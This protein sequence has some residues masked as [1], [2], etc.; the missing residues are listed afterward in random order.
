MILFFQPDTEQDDQALAKQQ[1]AMGQAA[2]IAGM[3]LSERRR[4]LTL[5]ADISA[6]P[7]AAMHIIAAERALSAPHDS[8]T[9]SLKR[10]V[11]WPRR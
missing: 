11:R 3:P 6:V 10:R 2:A 9:I 1:L 7:K 5:S 4:A 8:P